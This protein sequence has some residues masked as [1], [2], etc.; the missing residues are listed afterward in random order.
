LQGAPL[1]RG[2][3]AADLDS[4]VKVLLGLSSLAY[5]LKDRISEVDINPLIVSEKGALAVDALVVLR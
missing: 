2:R 5:S 1:L 4:M 3:P